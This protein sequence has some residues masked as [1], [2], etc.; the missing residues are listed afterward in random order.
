MRTNRLITSLCGLFA[1][2]FLSY[3][4][5]P[6]ALAQISLK[7]EEMSAV[8]VI[9]HI[10]QTT[11]YVFFYNLE[12][13][14]HIPVRSYDVSGS[15]ESILEKLFS[16]NDVLWRIQGKEIILKRNPQNAAPPKTA[17]RTVSGI[18]VDAS[19]KSPLIGATVHLKGTDNVAIS[20]LD[21]NFSMEGVTNKSILE[22]SYV[23]YEMREFRVGD[24][25]FLEIALSSAN[26]LEGVIIVGAGTQKKVSVTG[27]IVAIRGDELKAPSSSLTSTLA[28]K[29]PGIISTTT[30]GEPGSTS[31]FYIRGIGTFGGRSTPLILLDDIEISASDLNN[32]P[33][34]SIESFSILKDASATAIYGARGANGVMLITT[35]SGMENTKTK[36]HVSVENSVLQP[37]NRVEYVDGPTW[38]TIY[39]DAQYSRNPGSS[40]RYSSDVID[41]TRQGISPYVYP[42]ID[43][44]SLM[45]KDFNMNQ[46]ANVNIQGGG[47][48][49]TYYMGLQVNHDTGQL[50]VPKTYS[51]DS[52][53]KRWTYVFQNN[54]SYKP[55][56]TTKIDLKMN[57]QFGSQ[58]GPGVSTSNLFY[59][60]YNANPVSFPATFPAEDGDTH[61]RFGNAVLSGEKLRTNPYAEMLKSYSE[62]HYTTINASLK[63]DQN[64]EFITK[65]LSISALVNIKA[66]SQSSYTNTLAPYFYGIMENALDPNDPT[67]FMTR[68]LQKGTDYI[69]QGSINRYND[70]TF[71]FDARLNYNRRFGDHSVSAMLMYMQREFRDDVLPNRNQGFSGRATYD[72]KN[73]YLVEFNFGYNGTERIDTG[74]RFEFFPAVSLGYVISNENFWKPIYPVV[75]HFKIRASYGLVGSDETGTSAGAAHFLYRDNVN[76]SGA[77]PF[78]TGSGSSVVSMSGPIVYSYAVDNPCW[79]RAKKLDVGVDLVLFNQLNL[80]VDYFQEHR[81][82]ILQKRSSWPIIMGYDR[83]IPWANVGKVDNMGV[84]VS[85]NWSKELFKDFKIDLRG[86]FTYAKNKY[87][88]IDEP[89]YPYVWQTQTGKPISA[90][91]GYIAEGL[92]KDDD[93]VA[94]SASQKNLNSTVM[95]GDIKYRDINGDGTITEEDKVMLSPYGRMPQIQYG[96]GLNLNYKGFD[97]GVFF[98]GSAK[99]TLMI[100][101]IAPF[102]SDDNNQDRNLM[103]WIAE[104]YW[105]PSN[106]NPDAGYPRLGLTNAQIANNLVESSFWMRNGNF[107]RFKTL[108]FGYTYKFFRVFFNGDNIAVWSPFKLWDPELSWNA[109]PLQRTFNLGIQFNL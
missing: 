15:V 83:A 4:S 53:I 62:K 48:K 105:S 7:G 94:N 54:I 104:D 39:N 25:G 12:D 16:G 69:S 74:S 46:R 95:P 70:R 57:A 81:D 52:N 42:N 101:N 68:L 18:V 56:S 20:D 67:F 73:R 5:G 30:S 36:I 28:G 47:S 32:L 35:K 2:L 63:L 100:N 93:D 50:N 96:F 21:G 19:D 51:F 55:T 103:K 29:L 41:M 91:Y 85:L 34:E 6:E 97:F 109:Y 98:T 43:W 71:Y 59:A 79:E 102:C 13:V 10:Q 65:G 44:Y 58:S 11:D 92:F 26:E 33:S 82:R 99:R 23:G 40:P 31:D 75:N 89:D 60:V 80:T 90:T 27:A 87:V 8:Q 76:I 49:V 9:E 64:L 84:E 77:D 24:L 1:G 22:V 17:T 37:V 106:P 88:Y 86:N 66:Y 107:L 108:E 45:F 38:M 78:Y 61:L 3:M 72:Y 14:L